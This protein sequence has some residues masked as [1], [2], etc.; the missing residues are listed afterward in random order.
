MQMPGQS[1]L[2][3]AVVG[4]KPAP[5]SLLRGLTILTIL[6]TPLLF[7]AQYSKHVEQMVN[8]VSPRRDSFST[9]EILKLYPYLEAQDIEQA[10]TYAAW[11]VTEVE[12]PLLQESA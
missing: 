5:A 12:L 3:S 7:Y 4:S 8:M 1:E 2:S 6:A 11:R 10:L 9:P